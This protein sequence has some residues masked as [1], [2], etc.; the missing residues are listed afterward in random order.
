MTSSVS[1]VSAPAPAIKFSFEDVETVIP[2]N[3]NPVF[4]RD[5]NFSWS[6]E[7]ERLEELNIDEDNVIFQPTI[8][9][10]DEKTI[11]RT[12][13]WLSSC[14]QTVNNYKCQVCLEDHDDN[15]FKCSRCVDG[16]VCISQIFQMKQSGITNC[17]PNCRMTPYY[18]PSN[19]VVEKSS[20]R[21]C[22]SFSPRYYLTI[23]VEK[24]L[25]EKKILTRFEC[26]RR[27]MLQYADKPIV[28]HLNRIIDLLN[29]SFDLTLISSECY[30]I[31]DFDTTDIW[32]KSELYWES[33]DI[34]TLISVVY[35]DELTPAYK[36]C[37]I[38][39]L[40]RAELE[41]N[42]SDC[43]YENPINFDRSLVWNHFVEGLYI[44]NIADEVVD[45]IYE[46]ENN[47][48]LT[49]LLKSQDDVD[50]KLLDE[51]DIGDIAEA[52]CVHSYTELDDDLYF[53]IEQ[54]DNFLR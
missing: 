1:S 48:F 52:L 24:Y 32:D 14:V 12:T 8:Y 38:S 42:V 46:S 44:R 4:R 10:D 50:I 25:K 21:V 29:S 40:S 13:K 30:F 34:D 6:E 23:E 31:V 20:T 19:F 47:S 9:A 39:F 45:A 33:V 49:L 15:G 53:C 26:N 41:N 27:M 43:L 51:M 3:T 37:S 11:V 28:S 2:T 22:E 18:N 7:L 54:D 36:K 35:F 5:Y 16:I 17:C